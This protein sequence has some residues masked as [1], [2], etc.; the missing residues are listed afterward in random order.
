MTKLLSSENFSPHLSSQSHTHTGFSFRLLMS[1]NVHWVERLQLSWDMG[2]LGEKGRNLSFVG[3]GDGHRMSHPYFVCVTCCLRAAHNLTETTTS[4]LC[5]D[6]ENFP[7]FS[8]SSHSLVLVR[9]CRI[10]ISCSC[11]CFALRFSRT[12][13]EQQT[14]KFY[15]SVNCY[16]YCREWTWSN[17]GRQRVGKIMLHWMR[18]DEEIGCWARCTL[19]SASNFLFYCNIA[20]AAHLRVESRKGDITTNRISSLAVF[21]CWSVHAARAKVWKF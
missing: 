10:R 13:A 2:M 11:E 1:V 14:I 5:S 7:F 3:S 20:F 8:Y 17:G 12:F 19:C 4:S 15:E 6:T 16:F 21:E 18:D 9:T